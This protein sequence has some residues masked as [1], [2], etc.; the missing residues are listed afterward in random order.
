V[1]IQK[2]EKI[3]ENYSEKLRKIQ[4]IEVDEKKYLVLYYEMVIFGEVCPNDRKL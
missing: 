3:R 2:F 1:R 4:K